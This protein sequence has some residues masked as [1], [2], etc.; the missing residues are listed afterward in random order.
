VI[1][2]VI[3]VYLLDPI[4]RIA[5]DGNRDNAPLAAGRRQD[6]CRRSEVNSWGAST[7]HRLS[8]TC[9]EVTQRAVESASAATAVRRPGGGHGEPRY[10][11]MSTADV[12]AAGAS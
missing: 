3:I 10:G 9:R 8:Q 2:I 7:G 1:S 4:S 12:A 5:R 11:H 6:I